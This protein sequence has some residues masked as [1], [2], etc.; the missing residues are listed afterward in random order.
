VL[1]GGTDGPAL[2]R[3]EQHDIGIGADRDR[4]LLR[5]DAEQLGRIG[6]DQLDEAA[7]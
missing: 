1:L 2:L 6:R 5:I 3:V 7:R 4:A